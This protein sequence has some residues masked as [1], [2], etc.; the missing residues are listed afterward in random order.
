MSSKISPDFNAEQV[1]HELVT[2]LYQRMLDEGLNADDA[3]GNANLLFELTKIC[4]SLVQQ[5]GANEFEGNTLPFDD[6]TARQAMDLFAEALFACVLRCIRAGLPEEFKI[7]FV[8]NL[9]QD[10][11]GQAKQVVASTYGQEMTPGVTFSREQQVIWMTQ[12]AESVLMTYL[13]EYEKQYGELEPHQQPTEVTAMA[14]PTPM[15][16]VAPILATAPLPAPAPVHVVRIH[17]R[18]AATALLY[19]ALPEERQVALMAAFSPTVQKEV[20]QIAQNPQVIEHQCD[21]K[22]VHTALLE[23]KDM[24][25]QPPVPPPSVQEQ[26]ESV[27]KTMPAEHVLSLLKTER[28]GVRAYLAPWLALPDAFQPL[29]NLPQKVTTVIEQTLLKQLQGQI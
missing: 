3:Q 2:S 7:Q 24:M 16:T 14:P 9:A 6:S 26:L 1:A 11:Y 25:L 17:P 12:A 23:L 10:V 29:P 5:D 4:G 27:L 13:N 20:Q 22:A 28:P 15:D 19:N 8:Q 18:L 21:L